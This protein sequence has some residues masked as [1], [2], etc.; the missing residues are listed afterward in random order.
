MKLKPKS[1]PKARQ[2]PAQRVKPKAGLLEESGVEPSAV[3]GF[4]PKLIDEAR[5]RGKKRVARLRAD[6]PGEDAR[7]LGERLLRSSA[8]R[9]G[10]FGAATGA[11][12]LFALPLGLPAGVAVTL[13][14]EAELIVALLE[15]YGLE[16]EGERGRLRLVALWAGAGFADAAKTA[17]LRVGTQALGRVLAGSLPARLIARLNPVL[18]RA[19]LKRL[20]M[21]FL[22]RVLKLWPLLGAPIAY[23]IDRSALRTLGRGV[24]AT[25]DEVALEKRAARP[26]PARTRGRAASARKSRPARARGSSAADSGPG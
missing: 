23:A 24:L 14:L 10:W 21:G 12:S 11:V 2:T 4:L 15:V 9:A 19:I 1:K 3:P 20:G 7:A 18:L 16:A 25:L 17:G 26:G 13:F 5:A 6:F 8:N 22:P